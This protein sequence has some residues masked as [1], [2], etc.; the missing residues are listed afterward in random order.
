VV[1]LAGGLEQVQERDQVVQPDQRVDGAKHNN[2]KRHD[3]LLVS[4]NPT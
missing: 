4:F 1:L 2:V 3:D